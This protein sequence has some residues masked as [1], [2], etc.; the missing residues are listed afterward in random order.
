VTD[1]GHL[2]G[3][4]SVVTSVGASTIASLAASSS[5]GTAPLT[6][7]F[8]GTGSVSATPITAWSLDFGD[9][10]PPATGRR[11]LPSA[12]RHTYGV[13]TWGPKL[14]I[15]DRTGASRSATSTITVERA[16]PV[17]SLAYLPA[18]AGTSK[19]KHVIFNLQENR[20]FDSYFGTFPGADG[21][22]MD[23]TGVA[24][25]CNNDPETGTCIKP[26]HDPNDS[27]QGGP[28]N[29]PAS[30]TSVDSGNMD[31]FLQALANTA[32][33]TGAS[34]KDCHEYGSEDVMGYHDAR[35]IPNYWR[36]ATNYTLAD[37]FYEA[38]NSWSEPA[39]LS[40]VAGWSASCPTATGLVRTPNC[41]SNLNEPDPESDDDSTT[42]TKGPITDCDDELVPCAAPDYGYTDLTYLMH[43]KGVTWRYYRT[44]TTP[45][46]W[47][48]LPDF[49]DVH[50]DQQLD[51]V[52]D[53]SQFMV[54]AANG[55]LP[56]VAWLAPGGAESEHP[57]ASLKA[58]QAYTQS[59]IDAAMRGPDWNST[60]I[61][62]VWDDWGGF[63]DH[64][65]PPSVDSDGYGIRVP[66]ILISPYARPGYVDHQTLSF[67][68]YL[69]F[70][71]DVFLGGQRLDPA[72]DGRPDTRPTVRESVP[73]LGDLRNEFDFSQTPRP[74]D[75]IGAPR[76]TGGA[77]LPPA[78]TVPFS[79]K[80][81]GSGSADPMGRIVSWTFD[82]GDGTPVV[83]GSGAPSAH[84]LEH[85]Y[86]SAGHFRPSLTVTN[87][88]GL[89]TTS[90]N[91]VVVAG[92][93]GGPVLAAQPAQG[94]APMPIVLDTSG[95]TAAHPSSTTWRVDFGDGTGPVAGKGLPPAFLPTHTYASPGSYQAVLR[96]TQAGVT[97]TATS[98][99]VVAQP[100]KPDLSSP[101]V[102]PSATRIGLRIR[103]SSNGLATTASFRWGTTP[104]FGSSTA[105]ATF[106]PEAEGWPLDPFLTGLSPNTQYYVQAVATN[107]LGTSVSKVVAVKT[108]AS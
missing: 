27:N 20:S 61:F 82:A 55:N 9:G 28:H 76:Y 87:D 41:V 64:V 77:P 102:G 72:N 46:I 22:P 60:A 66:S 62:V 88:A 89:S 99:V 96:M 36:Y 98:L 3:T 101:S 100:A 83:N 4:S 95:S 11:K 90:Y 86:R 68:A 29:L 52:V 18:A 58:G 93:S 104:S 73:I 37:H 44:S 53:T 19:I 34:Q 70:V 7:G 50:D 32:V 39:H 107:A 42:A 94:F 91:D 30:Q 47:D 85:V 33:C 56:N 57:P 108:P 105:A 106:D 13:G 65:N 45:E 25:V 35:E 63:Y 23:S 5:G 15:T 67:D 92:R 38:V 54:D 8:D 26:Y 49:Q 71:E 21:I 79:V 78:G 48:P 59:V 43:A 80:F 97:K 31:G 14:T 74:P 17:S 81:D 12:L 2:N 1:N 103:V 40:I 69:K 16:G 75:P 24:T 6:V 10:S 51:D 84:L